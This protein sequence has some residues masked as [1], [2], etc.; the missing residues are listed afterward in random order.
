MT[1]DDFAQLLNLS[2]EFIAVG[3]PNRPGTLLAGNFI[4]IHN[5]DNTDHG[6]DAKAHSKFVRNTGFF[7]LPSGKKDVVSWHFTVDD[8]QVIQ[9][10]PI[11]EVAFHAKSGNKQSVAIEVCMND[12]IDQPAAFLRAARLTA[13]LLFDSGAEA[14]LDRVVPHLHWTGKKCPVLLLDQG[15]IGAK[16]QAFLDLVKAERS[17]IDP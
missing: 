14:A 5:T 9:Q 13:L 16:W 17:H 4:T 11:T 2:K 6:A 7:P 3:R 15:K 8:H 12:G 10:L 1:R